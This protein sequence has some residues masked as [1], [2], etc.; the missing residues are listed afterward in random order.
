MKTL[1]TY[2]LDEDD[3][4]WAKLLEEA[5]NRLTEFAP[6]IRIM[7]PKPK[8]GEERIRTAYSRFNRITNGE[9]DQSD[10]L[11][12]RM[13]SIKVFHA[14][15]YSCRKGKHPAEVEQSILQAAEN[16]Q[17][18]VEDFLDYVRRAQ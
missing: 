7:P 9:F 8:K 17:T 14:A 15:F 16:L 10:V 18:T 4:S 2:R 1:I 12:I 13:Y 11:W 5:F 3:P 6:E